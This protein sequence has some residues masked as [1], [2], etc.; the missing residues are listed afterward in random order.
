LN[1]RFTRYPQ[2]PRKRNFPENGVLGNL[3]HLPDRH[4]ELTENETFL[5]IGLVM[6]EIDHNG[7]HPN[8]CCQKPKSP[9]GPTSAG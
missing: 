8:D 6:S 1:N 2:T 4:R 7:Q 3:P 5:A 9:T